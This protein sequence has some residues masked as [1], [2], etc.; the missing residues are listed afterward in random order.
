MR[1]EII[2]NAHVI[3]LDGYHYDFERGH[4]EGDTFVGL[5]LEEVE[6]IDENDQ[7]YVTHEVREVRIP[8]SQ[9]RDVASTDR[10]MS[11]HAGCRQQ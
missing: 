4:V 2:E 11:P 7:V 10:K 6:A 3:T 1:G 8:L 9:V 5:L